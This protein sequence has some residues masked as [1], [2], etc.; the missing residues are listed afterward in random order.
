MIRNTEKIEWKVL[1]VK[2]KNKFSKLRDSDIE[3]LEGRM[4][5]LTHKVQKTYGYTQAKADKECHDFQKSIN[6]I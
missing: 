2:I 5:L 3:S 6:T 4:D 1:K